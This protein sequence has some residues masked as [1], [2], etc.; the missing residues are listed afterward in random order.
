MGIDIYLKWHDMNEDDQ[1]RQFTGMSTTAG[2]VGYLRE[3]YHGGPYATRILCR[4]A[5]EA[6]NCEAQIPAETL[7]D[8]LTKVTEP[9]ITQNVS[10]HDVAAIFSAMLQNSGLTVES[11]VLS[12]I[13]RPM[14]VEEAIR[15]RYARL[16]PDADKNE[17]NEVIKSFHD[18]VELAARKEAETGT[19][20]TIYASY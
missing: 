7:R 14:T 18:F 20:C 16:Y 4:E 10:G 3:A 13:T 9:A 12:D 8:R 1:T 11:Q 5:F 2:A 15:E 6:E 17:V 19:P